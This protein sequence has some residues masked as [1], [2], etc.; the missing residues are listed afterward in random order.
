MTM[1][2]FPRKIASPKTNPNNQMKKSDCLL[3]LALAI[4][5]GHTALAA[6]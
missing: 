3:H 1:A 5:A 4:A 2:F 6:P